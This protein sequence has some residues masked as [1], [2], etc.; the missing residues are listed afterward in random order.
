MLLHN[1]GDFTL[2]HVRIYPGVNSRAGLVTVARA[3][4]VGSGTHFIYTR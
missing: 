3:Y 4:A 1:G 2:R